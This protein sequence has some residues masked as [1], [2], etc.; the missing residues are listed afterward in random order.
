M[1][2]NCLFLWLLVVLSAIPIIPPYAASESL[3]PVISAD[4][5]QP[6]RFAV[7]SDS[8]YYDSA[9][10][11]TG[12]AFEAYLYGDRKMIRES[13]AILK[14]AI[15]AMKLE[16]IRFVLVSGDLTKDGELSSHTE[17]AAHIKELEDSGIEVYVIPG[18]HDIN[19][20]HAVSYSGAGTVPVPGVNPDDFVQIYNQFG[21][22]QAVSRDPNSLSYLVEP[23]AGLCVLAMDSCRYMENV[24]TPI[25]GGR[26]S[27]ETLDWILAQIAWARAGNKQILGFMHHGVVAHYTM[28]P[29]LFSEYLVEDWARISGLFANAGMQMVF[30]GHYHAQDI[31]KRPIITADTPSFVF[32][33]ETGSLVTY[34]TPYRIVSFFMPLY[35]VP[36]RPDAYTH[37]AP[38]ALIESRHI[39]QIDYDTGGI[40]FSQYAQ[41]YLEEGLLVLAQTI[42]MDTFGLDP[43]TAQACA[44][45]VV[46]AFEAH[47]VGDENPDSDTLLTAFSYLQMPD[48]ALKLIGIG[49]FSLWDDLFPADNNLAVHLGTG[50]TFP[51]AGQ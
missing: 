10:G 33:V 15:D 7:F 26:F 35:P 3:A 39:T 32:D 2:K 21:F 45:D 34:P 41:Q 4:S 16:N 42:L 9:L 25:V 5:G 23:V 31:V 36:Y 12:E 38:V 1:K 13:E 44:P 43:V 24:E 20:P 30:T 19:N 18:N 6:I 37:T 40:P 29:L 46:K 48:T 27:P 50:L 8:H 28:Q 22:E 17:F 11:T 49:I 51:I 47:Y 14:A